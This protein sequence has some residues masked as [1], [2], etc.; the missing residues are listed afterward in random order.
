MPVIL[1]ALP[2]VVSVGW[3]ADLVQVVKRTDHVRHAGGRRSLVSL[4]VLVRGL[5]QSATQ[6]IEHD[7]YTNQPPNTEKSGFI[8]LSAKVEE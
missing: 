7:T 8:H 5:D 1:F 4:G 2:A 6:Y 3:G